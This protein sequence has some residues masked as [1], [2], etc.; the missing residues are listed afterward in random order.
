MNE[1]PI[2]CTLSPAG[3]AGRA[4][5]WRALATTA[6]HDVELGERG[7][8]VRLPAEAEHELRRLIA[9]ESKC[10]AFLEFDLRHDGPDLCLT[11]EGPEEARPIIR[12]L[13]GL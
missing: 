9:A 12:G 3:Q 1:L 8:S 10:C 6:G 7:G 13:L 5:E 11:V 2:A 4:G